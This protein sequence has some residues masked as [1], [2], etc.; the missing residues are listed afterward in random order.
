MIEWKYR[1]SRKGLQ[2]HL[3]H[4]GLWDVIPDGGRLDRDPTPLVESYRRVVS[5]PV[6]TVGEWPAPLAFA[7]ASQM[8]A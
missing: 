3:L 2:D 8:V 7:P 4:L 1:W 6:A 5:D